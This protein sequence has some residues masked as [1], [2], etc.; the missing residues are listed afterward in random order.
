MN[1]DIKNALALLKHGLDDLEYIKN[2][3]S[4]IEDIARNALVNFKYSESLI[5]SEMSKREEID[6]C[7]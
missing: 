4:E 5:E 3:V 7:V 6:E 1:D 2:T